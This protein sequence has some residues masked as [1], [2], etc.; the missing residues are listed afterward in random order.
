MIRKAFFVTAMVAVA[1]GA[2]AL[3]LIDD[4]SIGSSRIS[5]STVGGNFLVQNN[6]APLLMERDMTVW[7]E[8]TD[9][10]D[11]QA[12]TSMKVANH[13]LNCSSDAE[14]DG[15][16]SLVYSNPMPNGVDF[17]AEQ[18]FDLSF[19][20]NDQPIELTSYAESVGPNPIGVLTA[21]THLTIPAGTNFKFHVDGWNI[22]IT[23]SNCDI[24]T[25]VF[26]TKKGGD[27]QLG[28]VEAV[29]EPTSV[30][31]LALGLGGIFLRRRRK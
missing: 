6:A 3:Q 12:R 2:N 13:M 20:Y 8:S 4:F 5:Q 9:D 18:A 21:V 15:H 17:S 25:F 29:P 31:V 14:T 28:R 11:F 16:F 24:V 22:P 19:V 26:D 23:W 27:F 30:A 10:P 7:L 1:A